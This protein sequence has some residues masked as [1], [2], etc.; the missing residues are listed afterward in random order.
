MP[1]EKDYQTSWDVSASTRR[2]V[3][4]RLGLSGKKSAGTP[5]GDAYERLTREMWDSYVADFVPYENKLIEY[6]TSPTVVSD[7]MSGASDMVDKSFATQQAMTQRRLKGLG[8]EL[9]PEEQEQ[10]KRSFGL[11]KSLA[12]VGAQNTVR[13][14]TVAR[15][16]GI[17]GSPVPTLPEI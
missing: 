14:M 3:D 17:L 10:Q 15:Q 5:V 1:G 13:D 12:D 4:T 2:W 11:A 8:L 16:K 9:N 6:A 7:A